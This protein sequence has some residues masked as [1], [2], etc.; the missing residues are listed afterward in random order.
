[1]QALF[2]PAIALMNRLGYSRKFA[3][4]GAL[5]LGMLVLEEL[6][7]L[8]LR[9]GRGARSATREVASR[10]ARHASS[11]RWRV[12]REWGFR[13]SMPTYVPGASP[14]RRNEPSSQRCATPPA[15]GGFGPAGTP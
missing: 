14:S 6:R 3:V 2:A 13:T 11:R 5:A 9:I 8:A 4:M 1:M 15:R 7:K 10:P 12:L